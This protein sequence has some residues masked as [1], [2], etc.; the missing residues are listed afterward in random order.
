MSKKNGDRARFNR[1]HRKKL[2]RRERTAQVKQQNFV[3]LPVTVA[4]VEPNER[5]A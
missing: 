3:S 1:Q 2:L 5:S 4:G